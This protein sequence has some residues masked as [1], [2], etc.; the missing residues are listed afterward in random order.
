MPDAER[1]VP[2]V[3]RLVRRFM[4]QSRPNERFSAFAERLGTEALRE[5]VAQS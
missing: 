5:G 4:A 2:V 1:V 3:E